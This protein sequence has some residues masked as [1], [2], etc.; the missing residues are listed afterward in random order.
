MF[1]LDNSNIHYGVTITHL[2]SSFLYYVKRTNIN[3]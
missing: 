2:F 1:N 3:Y